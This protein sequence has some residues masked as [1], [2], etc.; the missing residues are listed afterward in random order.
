[1]LRNRANGP[2]ITFGQ[3][4]SAEVSVSFIE[5]PARSNTLLDL[6]VLPKSLVDQDVQQLRAG[7]FQLW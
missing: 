2:G 5:G 1:M 3:S 7:R 4:S 6:F